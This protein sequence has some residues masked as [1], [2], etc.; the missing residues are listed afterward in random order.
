MEKDLIINKLK[1]THL[2]FLDYVTSLSKEDQCYSNGKWTAS[3]QLHHI[4]LSIV[5]L[6]KVINRDFLK[7]L[8]KSEK[9][10][11]SYS[12]IVQI[13]SA[14]FRA[15][16]K[17]PESVIPKDPDSLNLPD[18]IQSFE[19]CLAEITSNLLL[20]T[21]AELDQH[22][23]AHPVLGK[24]TIREMLYFT[25]YHA[26]HHHQSVRKVME[27]KALNKGSAPSFD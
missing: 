19:Q 17:S 16:V 25:I 11:K 4:Y 13:S 26:E 12:E 6:I 22:L 27:E 18:L 7:N 15:H 10:S 8:F 20:I 3:Q 2:E 14:K 24:L 5:P 23:I 9:S 21:D 1:G